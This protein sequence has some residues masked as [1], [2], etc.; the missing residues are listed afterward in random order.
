ME[1]IPVWTRKMPMSKLRHAISMTAQPVTPFFLPTITKKWHQNSHHQQ[2]NAD[3]RNCP[4]DNRGD[5]KVIRSIF[6]LQI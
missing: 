4:F 5:V 6:S 3:D 1:V 2:Q